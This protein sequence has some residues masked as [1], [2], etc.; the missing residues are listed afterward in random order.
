MKC[1]DNLL[2]YTKQYVSRLVGI[3]NETKSKRFNSPLDMHTN[4]PS[5]TGTTGKPI[6]ELFSAWK[7]TSV[8]FHALN[9][10]KKNEFNH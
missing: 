2:K 4:G 1:I 7:W 6:L 10:E 5:L 9:L 3:N 8:H